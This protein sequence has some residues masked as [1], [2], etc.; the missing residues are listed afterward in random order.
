M[1][2]ALW[3][4]LQDQRAGLEQIAEAVMSRAFKI[5]LL[6]RLEKE[7][8][9]GAFVKWVRAA[10]PFNERQAQSYM[11]VENHRAFLE[12]KVKRLEVVTVQ[13]GLAE[14]EQLGAAEPEAVP[15]VDDVLA[16][17]EP[18]SPTDTAAASPPGETSQTSP[19]T[20][21]KPAKPAKAPVAEPA[22]K[23]GR[24]PAHVRLPK[25]V[26]VVDKALDLFAR[27]AVERY[28]GGRMPDIVRGW[29]DATEDLW[30]QVFEL[31]VDDIEQLPE[32]PT[33]RNAKSEERRRARREKSGLG[34]LN[35]G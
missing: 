5:G 21:A 23:K 3:N 9:P 29:I 12:P 22:E 32:Y 6:L 7:Q 31:V 4:E 24:V 27:L 34:D 28:A 1:I 8:R 2:I 35:D 14:I 10:M 15:T 25:T 33:G 30:P 26:P 16:E 20:S 11:S 13:Q 18:V 19:A 17:P